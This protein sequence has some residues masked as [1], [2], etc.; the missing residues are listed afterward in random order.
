MYPNCRGPI[1]AHKPSLQSTSTPAINASKNSLPDKP[2]SSA[3]ASAA[4]ATT[5]V[6]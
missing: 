1:L 4:G 6:G 2:F 5:T 3:I